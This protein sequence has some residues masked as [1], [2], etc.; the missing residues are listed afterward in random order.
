MHLMVQTLRILLPI[1]H[2]ILMRQVFT[3]KTNYRST[4]PILSLANRVIERNERIYPKKLE[5]GKTRKNASPSL[6]DVQ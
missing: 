1:Q 5:V 4:A 6:T 2:V 3:L